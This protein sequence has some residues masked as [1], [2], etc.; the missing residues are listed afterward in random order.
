[1]GQQVGKNKAVPFDYF[2]GLHGD[3]VME[4]GAVVSESVELATLT[5]RVRC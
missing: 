2:S 1:M 4:H 5:A 3:R